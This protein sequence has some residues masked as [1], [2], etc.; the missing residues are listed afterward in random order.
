MGKNSVL[1][2]LKYEVSKEL[3]YI[4]TDPA[5]LKY[6]ISGELG[7]PEKSEA[8]KSV[9]DEYSR[10]VDNAKFE[11]AKELG[12]QLNEGYNGDITSRDAGR[13]GGRIGGKIGGNMVKRMVAFAENQLKNSGEL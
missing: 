4:Q 11:A 6:E 8:H 5:N 3:G 9:K 7:I 12:I 13:I 2:Q 10:Y 1:D